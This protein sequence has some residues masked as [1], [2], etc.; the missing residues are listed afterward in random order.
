MRG[1]AR[2]LA[3]AAPS[4]LGLTPPS[5]AAIIDL[6][7]VQIGQ[8]FER[9][10]DFTGFSSVD[11]LRF[12]SPE[13]AEISILSVSM[14][15]VA[16]VAVSDRPGSAG[17]FY[18]PGGG[19]IFN[20]MGSSIIGL[21]AAARNASL[22]SSLELRISF[23][24]PPPPSPPKGDLTVTPLPSALGLVSLAMGALGLLGARRRRDQ[25]RLG[26]MA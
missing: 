13:R 4:L 24:Q 2:A 14:S 16:A 21:S 5:A 6:G 7:T 25:L 17:F 10:I 22:P 9:T 15:N 8:S 11:I 3:L 23:A 19:S 26:T 18:E 1:L 20:V 12:I